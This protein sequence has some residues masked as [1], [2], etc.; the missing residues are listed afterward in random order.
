MEKR[1]PNVNANASMIARGPQSATRHCRYMGSCTPVSTCRPCCA[2]KPQHVR[3]YYPTTRFHRSWT[4]RCPG[5]S[6]G[7]DRY[8]DSERV[9]PSHY[10]FPAPA[11]APHNSEG[12]RARLSHNTHRPRTPPGVVWWKHMGETIDRS[13]TAHRPL[14]DHY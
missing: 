6:R 9:R 8:S 2:L 1:T 11:P 14:I 4:A 13:S 12:E 7:N 3:R 5:A 10:T